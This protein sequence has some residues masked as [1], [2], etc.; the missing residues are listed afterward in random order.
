MKLFLDKNDPS[1]PERLNELKRMAATS[2]HPRGAFCFASFEEFNEF[3]E[4]FRKTRAELP[5][6][7]RTRQSID[8]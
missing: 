4:I 8:Q 6:S 3:K 2:G 1:Y 7:I 5:K